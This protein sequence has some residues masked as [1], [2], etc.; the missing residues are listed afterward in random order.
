ML[1]KKRKKGGKIVTYSMLILDLYGSPT[2]K[3]LQFVYDATT[4]M[5]GGLTD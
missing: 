3:F 2:C 4:D 1:E 5:I